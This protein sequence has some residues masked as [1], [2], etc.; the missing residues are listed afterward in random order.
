MHC[1][2]R[3]NFSTKLQNDLNYHIAKKH[4]APKPDITF[5]CK[6]CYAEFPGFDAL[7][8]HKNTQQGP[9][10]GLGASNIDVE[11]IVEDVDDQSLG[12]ELESCRHLLTVTKMENGKHRVFKFAMSSTDRSLL[13]NKLDYVFK[14]LK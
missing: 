9:Q 6:L 2:Q 11:D 8:Q 13:N 14:E 5:R 7:R 10:I 12:E 3:S 1:S 4:S